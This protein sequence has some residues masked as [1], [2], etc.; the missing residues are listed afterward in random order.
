ME[1]VEFD[2]I[3]S[4]PA[5]VSGGIPS[6]A[7]RPAPSATKARP[8]GQ[9]KRFVGV[10]GNEMEAPLRVEIEIVVAGAHPIAVVVDEHVFERQKLERSVDIEQRRQRGLQLVRR[11]LVQHATKLDEAGP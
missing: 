10:I 3:D 8:A 1:R 6:G 7:A 5:C 2:T 11:R 4:R 9:R